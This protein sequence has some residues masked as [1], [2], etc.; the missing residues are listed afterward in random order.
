MC[1]SDVT[2]APIFS[3]IISNVF[4]CR[5]RC[6]YFR[7]IFEIS[8][9]IRETNI[10][11]EGNYVNIT[12]IKSRKW[13]HR[14]KWQINFIVSNSYFITVYLNVMEKC[15]LQI[16]AAVRYICDDKYD[17]NCYLLFRGLTRSWVWIP[18]EPAI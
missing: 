6:C 15:W 13:D 16:F 12:S 14:G 7:K 18:L 17:D 10:I 8:H 3:T 9:Q 5:K 1:S 2:H 4:L 11:F